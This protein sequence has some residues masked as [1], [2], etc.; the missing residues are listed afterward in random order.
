MTGR[1][2]LIVSATFG[3]S[4]S[5]C[6]SVTLASYGQPN[7][8]PTACAMAASEASAK[9]RCSRRTQGYPSQI[10]QWLHIL[11]LSIA[12]VERDEGGK[13]HQRLDVHD[14]IT[15][16]VQF[17]QTREACHLLRDDGNGILRSL[18]FARDPCAGSS[19]RHARVGF[20]PVPS[21]A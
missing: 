19:L 20:C 11:H 10:S 4:E 14:L 8:A 13:G 15:V 7:C 12:E 21:Q 1:T 6:R 17:T 9:R 5:W 2:S 16:K 18:I 3:H